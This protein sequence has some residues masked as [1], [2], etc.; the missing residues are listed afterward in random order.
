MSKIRSQRVSRGV[1]EISSKAPQRSRQEAL[2]SEA[3]AHRVQKLS[4]QQSHL[5]GYAA[6][7]KYSRQSSN[8]MD[9]VL[10]DLLVFGSALLVVSAFLY[11][12]L[13]PFV[14]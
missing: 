9:I 7:K 2:S 4:D 10:K 11:F 1:H 5:Q 8:M 13:K 14:Y 12:I 3:M 6:A